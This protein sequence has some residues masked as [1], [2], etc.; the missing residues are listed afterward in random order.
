MIRAIGDQGSPRRAAR[1][2]ILTSKHI[3]PELLGL[4]VLQ[5]IQVLLAVVEVVLEGSVAVVAEVTLP[6]GDP[7]WELPLPARSGRW[8]RAWRARHQPTQSAEGLARGLACAG[9]GRLPDSLGGTTRA[10]AC[11]NAPWGFSSAARLENSRLPSTGQLPAG[12]PTPLISPLRAVLLPSL[13]KHCL[14]SN[15]P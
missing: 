14:L 13:L 15:L 3:V 10:S 8:V 11:F 12:P 7:R 1:P 9:G 6:H 5:P 4:E 2:A